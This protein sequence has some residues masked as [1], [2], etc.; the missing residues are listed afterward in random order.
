MEI[1]TQAFNHLFPLDFDNVST[2]PDSYAWSTTTLPSDDPCHFTINYCKA[3][4]LVIDIS[5]PGA[6]DLVKHACEK[7]RAYK[8]SIM[9]FP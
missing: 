4:M 2:L 8:S 1:Q 9:A 5:E 6:Y 7:W 3:L